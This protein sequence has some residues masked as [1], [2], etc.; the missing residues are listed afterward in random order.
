MKIYIAWM[1]GKKVLLLS[2]MLL[3]SF[4]ANSALLTV[5]TNTDE[6]NVNGACSLRE[7]VENAGNN[8]QSGSTDCPAGSLAVV[9]KIVFD[10]ALN[11]G[12]MVMTLGP[13]TNVFE[14][15]D[16]LLIEGNGPENTIID[17]NLSRR[18]FQITTTISTSTNVEMTG[19][20]LTGAKSTSLGAAITAGGDSNLSL[21]NC[22]FV[23]NV[24]SGASSLAGAVLFNGKTLSVEKCVFEGNRSERSGNIRA[25]GA[26]LLDPDGTARIVDSVFRLNTVTGQDYAAGGAIYLAAGT[27]DKL[28]IERT[29]FSDNSAVATG[30]EEGDHAY[31][32]ALF[33]GVSQGH[34]AELL[35]VTLSGNKVKSNAGDA[36]GG[37]ISVFGGTMQMNN[38]TLV[39]NEA[40]GGVGKTTVGGIHSD[41]D[42]FMQNSIVAENIG[43]SAPDCSG[44]IMSISP[45]YNL[46]RNN[47]GCSFTAAS[48]D[49][50]GDVEGGGSAISAK[51][52]GLSLNGNTSNLTKTHALLTGSPAIDS[53]D[54]NLPG[55]SGT[56][57]TTDQRGELR[58]V[59]GDLDGG[60]R[61][62]IGAYETDGSGTVEGDDGGVTSS[63]G[64]GCS[65]A[66]GSSFDPL[67]YILLFISI[68][69]LLSSRKVLD[70]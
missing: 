53:A 18:I 8:D 29:E 30:G 70:N 33:L 5:T 14:I 31:G 10:P 61:C 32:G 16:S 15:S 63:G 41:K 57:P 56:C 40:T 24:A 17:G 46:L 23:E 54:P 1:R 58:P 9:D 34:R 39:R 27:G 44:N 69:Y 36:L 26:M 28:I 6:M 3:S 42:V 62:D 55:G 68:A 25:G 51:I 11:K 48:Q 66:A 2:F 4:Q 50:V 35:N 21:S 20:T 59:D 67:L 43:L 64:G 7:A 22:A 38:T 37:A 45:G 47:S 49:I 13:S 52:A 65:V 19:I 12:R 60:A